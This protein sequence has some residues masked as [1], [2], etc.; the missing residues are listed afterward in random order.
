M[1]D[2]NFEQVIGGERFVA[3][4]ELPCVPRAGDSVDLSDL[5][6][7]AASGVQPSGPNIAIRGTVSHVTWRP[8]FVMVTLVS[9]PSP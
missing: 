1:I 9:R 6:A 4:V 3:M 5:Y 7:F 8:R 2:V